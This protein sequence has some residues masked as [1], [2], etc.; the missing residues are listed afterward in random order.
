MTKRSLLA[1]NLA[2]AVLALSLVGGAATAN[3]QQAKPAPKPPANGQQQQ[4]TN[5]PIPALPIPWVKHCQQEPTINKEV[6]NLEQ[7]I[8]TDTGQFLVRFGIFEVKD[9]P[10]KAFIVSFPTGLLLRNGFRVALANEQ[11]I[12][13]TFIMCDNQV[14]RGDVQID[15][16]FI[17]RM[18]KA[19]GLTLQVANAVGRVISYPIG[20]GD[21]AKV[22]DGPPTDPKVFDAELKKIQDKVKA[23]QEELQS[24][25]AKRDEQTKQGLEKLGA[26]K[27]KGTQPAQ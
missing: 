16:G 7:T 11:P 26:E 4:P 8:I 22:Y 19:P 23:R 17:D 3:A 12:L 18:K 24:E 6:C 25:A 1:R 14:C 5:Q 9:D 20:L 2:G 10:K 27:L 15:Q 21:F 13:G